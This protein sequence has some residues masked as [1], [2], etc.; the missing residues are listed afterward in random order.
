MKKM[1]P[2]LL[3][4]ASL[5]LPSAWAMPPVHCV[6]KQVDYGHVLGEPETETVLVDESFTPP[7]A[8]LFRT[9]GFT[10]TSGKS[11]AYSMDVLASSSGGF[12]VSLHIGA[13]DTE[14]RKGTQTRFP[15]LPFQISLSASE[16]PLED[17][18]PVAS[19]VIDLR[20]F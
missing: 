2:A 19:G 6:L 1:I 11:Y 20:C 5:P 12:R 3:V 13:S 15:S 14:E 16:Y 9:G 8:S 10:E 18:S 17:A 7:P 4:I